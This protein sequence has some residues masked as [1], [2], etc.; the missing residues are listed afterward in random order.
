[1]QLQKYRNWQQ[2]FKN[3]R[4]NLEEES[5][6]R[7]KSLHKIEIMVIAIISSC[8]IFSNAFAQYWNNARDYEPIVIT[9]NDMPEFVHTN[10]SDLYVYSYN[11]SESAW[12]QIPFQF[13]E[14]DQSND[15]LDEKKNGLFNFNDE[16][17]FMAKDMG[18]KAPP[19]SWIDDETSKQFD[20][21]EISVTD[22]TDNDRQGWVYIYRSTSELLDANM[23]DY[24]YYIPNPDSAG[25]DTIEATNYIEGHHIGG[26]ADYWL[27]PG[28]AG[29]GNIDF[30]DRQK[31]RLILTVTIY[32][33]DIPFEI[34]NVMLT[35]ELLETF[36]PTIKYKDGPVRVIRGAEWTIELYGMVKVFSLNLMYYPYSIESGGISGILKTEDKVDLIRQSFDF[37][38]D[39]VEMN[40]YNPYNPSGLT[41]DGNPDAYYNTLEVDTTN[42]FMI[43]GEP[44]AIVVL[45]NISPLGDEQTIYYK[46]DSTIDDYDTGDEKSYGDS[47]IQIDGTE[48]YI[49]GDISITYESYFLSANEQYALGEELAGNFSSPLQLNINSTNFVPVEMASFNASISKNRVILNWTTLSESNNYGFE[50]QRR[51]ET[52]ELWKNLGFINGQGTSNSPTSY[53]YVDKD[54]SENHYFYRL[55]QID[56]D[57]SFEYSS[58]IEVLLQSPK[59]FVLIQNYPNPFNPETVIS[60][61]I[62]D[63]NGESVE[64]ELVIFNL[65]GDE[66]R[67][68]V[69]KNQA[70]GYYNIIWD[71][72][73]NSGMTV[74]AGTYV[75]QIKAGKFIQ[76][77]KMT[78]LR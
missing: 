68:L 10:I 45:F 67:T 77:K 78:L 14:K 24:V 23:A 70:A 5:M 25:A 58:T 60:Y 11:A 26:L 48:T 29:G 49:V 40:F 1:M 20:R 30:L 66:V 38:S 52:D 27:I 6:S 65:L 75:Y 73:D 61:Q 50:L 39:A 62:P 15:F 8:L 76:S 37:N 51:S 21:V 35:E 63:L 3:K 55:K 71:G 16:L 43:T 47:G 46:D 28:S 56:F 12:N 41:I 74:S 13:D 7:I 17:I 22:T 57:G 9:G 2:Q 59:R 44:G 18:D 64:V 69:R 31:F 54:I 4:D 19:E 42:W 32:F 33:G 34:P 72:R 36:P 53:S